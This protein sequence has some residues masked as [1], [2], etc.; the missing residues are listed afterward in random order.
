LAGVREVDWFQTNPNLGWFVR[1]NGELA[2]ASPSMQV[3]V[4]TCS[5]LD[6]SIH[7]RFLNFS[8][9]L[10]LAYAPGNQKD[11][12]ADWFRPLLRP[13]SSRAVANAQRGAGSEYKTVSLQRSQAGAPAFPNK[14][15]SFPAGTLI[16][17][18]TIDSGQGDSY[19]NGMTISVSI[20]RRNG[21]QGGVYTLS[22]AIDDTGNFFFSSPQKQLQHA[23][24]PWTVG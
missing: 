12:G 6:A 3:C 10:A 21:F 20:A 2:A 15:T 9:R 1:T 24:R 11:G 5:W 19:Y 7:T 22:K 13:H 16:N 14:L 23:R 18:A 8:P 4:M 17:L